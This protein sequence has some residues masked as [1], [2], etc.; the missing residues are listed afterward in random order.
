[1]STWHA[2]Y[3]PIK[4]GSEDAVKK[5]FATSGRPQ[6]EIT[7]P[8]GTV[9]GRLLATMAFVG[10]GAAIRVIEVDG[11]L[12]VVAAHMSRQPEV[13][14]FE[15]QLEEHLTE[16]RDMLSPEGARAFFQ[17]AGMENVLNRRAPAAGE[18][19]A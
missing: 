17:K 2:L 14:E 9:V 10:E 3:Y 19:A 18:K 13:K 15:R 7:A 4:R 6:F 16:E 5:L 11:P 12:P 8:D 1:M